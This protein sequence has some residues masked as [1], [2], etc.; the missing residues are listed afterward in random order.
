MN[1]FEVTLLISPDTTKSDLK[2]I[3]GI[4]EEIVVTQE[5]SITGK[6]DWGLRDLS[7]KIN[8]FKKAFYLFFQIN[9]EGQKIKTLKKNISLNEKLFAT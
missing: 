5:G 6:E 8:S 2:N 3:E 4:F 1:N 7:Y 9:V